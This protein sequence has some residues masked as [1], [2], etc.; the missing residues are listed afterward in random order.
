[1]SPRFQI[2][3][4]DVRT[5]QVVDEPARDLEAG[6]VR[7]K[8]DSF[9]ITANNVTYAAA[10]DMLG[11]WDFFPVD[12]PWGHV[13][14]M[15]HGEVVE[16]A[17]PDIEAG[18][19]YFGFFPMAAEHVFL[20]EPTDSGLWDAG[21]HRAAHAPTY[22]QFADV[23]RDPSYDAARESHVALLRGLFMTGW[24]AEDLLDDNDNFGA[25]AVLVTS[26]SSKTSIAA[27]WCLQQRGVTSVGVT[28]ERNADFVGKLGCYDE[29]VTYD[30]VADL[31]ATRASAVIDMAG[32]RTVLG[33]IHGHFADNLKYSC[34]VGASHW[35][36]FG[37]GD[38]LPGPEPTFF[39]APGQTEKRN[40]DWGPG[41]VMRRMGEKWV[42]YL[43]FV[44]TWFTIDQRSGTDALEAAWMASVEGTQPPDQGLIISLG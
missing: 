15:G 1:M 44:D 9:A 36:D 2:D 19:R 24:L 38:P 42:E 23:S 7:M 18:G 31:D 20:A 8:V 43:D 28:S 32:S 35:E 5:T 37:P 6:E 21:A 25:E 41:Q 3:R 30:N 13:P 10:G 40:A 14:A 12:L 27:G 39:F 26:A 22:R 17:N 11:Y 29:V 4:S 34:A 33:S 16:S